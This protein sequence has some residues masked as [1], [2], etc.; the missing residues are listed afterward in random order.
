M[1]GGYQI[2]LDPFVYTNV[3][4]FTL[5]PQILH[6]PGILL[7][8]HILCSFLRLVFEA[9]WVNFWVPF[10]SGSTGNAKESIKDESI[11]RQCFVKFDKLQTERWNMR[12][13]CFC[14]TY[15]A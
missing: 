11:Y 14:P 3:T 15:A 1:G 6:L 2:S 13:L 4:Y 9:F 12:L 7:E 8:K 10:G 5:P